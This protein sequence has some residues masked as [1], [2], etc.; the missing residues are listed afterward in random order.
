MDKKKAH[1]SW[2]KQLRRFMKTNTSLTIIISAVLLLEMMMGVMFYAA[3]NFIQQTMERMVGVEMNAIYLCIRNKLTSVEVTIDNMSW[4]VSES[5]D[6]PEWMLDLSRRMVKNNPVI[7]GSG[8]AFVPNYYPNK[9]KFFEPY[10]ARRDQDSI[11][12]MQIGNDTIDHTQKEYFRVPVE[13]SKSHWSEPYVDIVGAQA[14]ITTYSTPIR[15]DSNRIVGIVFAD[16]STKLLEE[17][18]NEEKIYQSTQRFLVTGNYHML[19]GDDSPLFRQVLEEVKA[20]SDK[21]EYLT[22]TAEDGK[23]HHVFYTLVGGKTDWILINI[24]DDSEVFG[25]LRLMRLLLLLP[26]MLGLFFAWFIVWRSSRSLER[27]RQV[28]AEKERIGG[29]LRVAS[30]IQQSMLPGRHLY[31]DDVDIY[32]ALTPAR[33]VGGDLYDYYIRDEKLF[34]CIGDVSGKGAPSAMVMAV[35][36]SLFRAFSAHENNPAR[37]MH[38]INEASCRGNDSNIFVTMFIGVLDLPTGNL[39]YCDAGHDS[40]LV[41]ENGEVKMEECEPHL[42]LGVFE[43]T[44]YSIQESV[45]APDSTLFLYTDGL[46]EA[47]RGYKQYFGLQRTK[48]VLGKCAEEHWLP[49]QILEKVT[50]EVHR[51]VGDA[52][53]SDDLTMLAIHYT[54]KQFE[55]KLT[56]TL[57]IK[58]DVHDVLKLN[59]FQKSF[60]AKMGLE[61]SLARQLQLGVE[62]AVVNV[63][64]YAYP[65]GTDGDI[66]VKMMSDGQSLKIIIV[67]SGVVFD[68]TLKE[69]TDTTLS[70]EERQIGGLGI[71]LVRELMDSINYERQGGKNVLTLIK[72]LKK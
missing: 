61:T 59:N 15:N 66:T 18:M 44:K 53:Q 50:E 52:E 1:K 24:L 51:F 16:I 62:E 40:P 69:D 45:L 3:Q 32:G 33:E 20:D 22:M 34:F 38:A 25:R 67:D 68:P 65:I 11:V 2:W 35:I 30:E 29:E 63:I 27:L 14:V 5:L 47:K 28:N 36:H 10:S 41:I 49:Q 7:W 57:S 13:Q 17:I 60:Y 54:P 39:R 4:V 21:T 37:I 71:Y 8:V 9:G 46:T 56:E 64:D 23:K 6:E 43:D 55:S 26:T 19:A 31:R 48:D 70:A 42:P 58:N 72:N 12:S